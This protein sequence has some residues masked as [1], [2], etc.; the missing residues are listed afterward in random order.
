MTAS[1]IKIAPSILSADFSRLGEQVAEAEKGGADYIHMDIMDGHFVPNLTIGPMVV[2][3][4]RPWTRLPLDVHMMVTDPQLYISELAVAGADIITVHAEAPIHLHRVIHQIK[5]AGKKAGVALNPATP[6][7]AVE[8]VLP[9]LDQVLVMTVNPGFGG[10]A[11]IESMVDKIGRM[12]ALLDARGLKAD[13]E[14][15][16]GISAQ[17]A[18]AAVKAGARVL[19]AGSA[20]YN[21]RMSVAE[22][23]ARIRQSIS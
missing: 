1:T 7:A 20:V 13:L 21:S 12:R 22:G 15:D 16:G 6:V 4:I 10:Q 18:Q 14:V 17:T 8:E 2:K 11:F 5:E 19:V 3:A 9:D 23:I